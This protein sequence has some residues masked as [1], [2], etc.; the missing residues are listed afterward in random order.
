MTMVLLVL[1]SS[2]LAKDY[3]GDV[4]TYKVFSEVSEGKEWLVQSTSGF[5]LCK[6]SIMCVG[7]AQSAT[8][9]SYAPVWRDPLVI[10]YMDDW[11]PKSC[12]LETCRRT[13]DLTYDDL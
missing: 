5:Y 8:I 11:P 3:D 12:M 10:Y 4:Y 1:L 7:L 13:K 6:A 2:T 9:K